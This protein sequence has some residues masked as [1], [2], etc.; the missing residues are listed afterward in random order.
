[1]RDY[2]DTILK[3]MAIDLNETWQ[4]SCGDLFESNTQQP[5]KEKVWSDVERKDD[6]IALTNEHEGWSCD[7]IILK[8]E[9]VAVK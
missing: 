4:P 1:M 5:Q 8:V 2:F 9:E 6:Y 7:H 3:E